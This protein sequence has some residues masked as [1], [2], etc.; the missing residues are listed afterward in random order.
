MTEFE[1]LEPKMSTTICVFLSSS[2][3]LSQSRNKFTHFP[4]LSAASF[5][6]LMI[7]KISSY[8]G[9]QYARKGLHF[10]TISTDISS[11][12][13]VQNSFLHL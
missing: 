13:I 4:D 2:S 1:T 7:I 9:S 10:A 5:D 3:R 8:V 12:V 11:T 6:E